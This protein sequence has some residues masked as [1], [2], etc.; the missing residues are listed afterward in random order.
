MFRNV[1]YDNTDVT[2]TNMLALEGDTDGNLDVDI[3]DFN[4][5]AGSFGATNAEWTDADFD[6]DMDVD[7]TDF[8]FL[9]SNFGSYSLAAPAL[10]PEPTTAGLVLVGLLAMTAACRR[11][12]STKF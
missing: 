9:A 10:I 6:G 1:S 11:R 5:L 7:I 12:F 2:F 8:N 4:V 3:T